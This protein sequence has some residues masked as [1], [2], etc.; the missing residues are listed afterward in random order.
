MAKKKSGTDWKQFQVVMGTYG[1]K[2]LRS[3]SGETVKS[4]AQAKAIAY[5]EARAAAER[6]KE[7]RTWHGRT[8]V[9][10]RKVD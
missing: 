10:P 8:R 4:P 3:S 2:K 9:R 5:S 7:R 1:K 6:G